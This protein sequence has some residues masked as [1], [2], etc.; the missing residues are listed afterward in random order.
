MDP[1]VR[2]GQRGSVPSSPWEG[3][4]AEDR[5]GV[6]APEAPAHIHVHTAPAQLGS[7]LSCAG[8][9]A[10]PGGW[11]PNEMSPRHHAGELA[12]SRTK[13]RHLSRTRIL[14][15]VNAPPPGRWGRLFFSSQRSVSGNTCQPPRR[16]PSRPSWLSDIQIQWVW[17]LPHCRWQGHPEQT[18]QDTDELCSWEIKSQFA[19]PLPVWLYTEQK[20]QKGSIY[21]MWPFTELSFQRRVQKRGWV[22]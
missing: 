3:N 19:K 7:T 11:T 22:P 14:T 18:S 2:P 5:C 21:I 6:C 16:L 8:P 1:R 12:G 13:G 10:V 15:A 17:S 4:K 20:E 9:E